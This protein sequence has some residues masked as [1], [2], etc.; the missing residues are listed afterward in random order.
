MTQI[1]KY[2]RNADG[3]AMDLEGLVLVDGTG[4]GGARFTS[5]PMGPDGA[6]LPVKAIAFMD[7]AGNLQSS[8][9]GPAGPQGPQGIQGPAG[10]N[11]TNGVDG[12]TVRYGAADPTGADGVDGD[13]YINTTS[14]TIFGP[15]A[16][17]AWPAGTSLVGPQ[18]PAGAD[19]AGITNG[20]KG[21]V[22]ISGGG[23]GMV[24]ESATP[25]SGTFVVAGNIT[26]SGNRFFAQG[27]ATNFTANSTLTAANLLSGMISMSGSTAITLTLPTGTLMDA[28]IMGGNLPVDYAFDWSLENAGTAAC[29][30]A[31]GTGHTLAGAAGTDNQR[32]AAGDAGKF[33]TRKTAANTFITTRV[34]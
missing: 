22:V 11:G 14:H 12:K 15:K 26:I 19:G 5:V 3:S 18:G 32:V 29:S 20:D 13:F 2:P 16:G 25:G 17:G 21:D 27:A 28:A 24:V 4:N 10:T 34:G 9:Q 1:T 33:R 7:S 8:L 31:A 6:P 23:S 30:L